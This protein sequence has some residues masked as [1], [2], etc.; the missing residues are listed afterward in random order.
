MRFFEWVVGLTVGIANVSLTSADYVPINASAVLDVPHTVT[1]GED[2][3]VHLNF[4][5]SAKAG[6][7]HQYMEIYAWAWTQKEVKDDWSSTQPVLYCLLD[8][9]VATNL[10][11]ISLNVPADALPD[12]RMAVSYAL[13]HSDKVGFST[14]GDQSTDFNLTGGKATLSDWEVKNG[15]GAVSHWTT[16]LPCTSVDC[17]RAC[18][19]EHLDLNEYYYNQGSRKT[20]FE[21]CV[22]GC[23]GL[24]AMGD[25]SSRTCT[26][27]NATKTSSEENESATASSSSDAASSSVDSSG[28]RAAGSDLVSIVWVAMAIALCTLL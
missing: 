25:Y 6:Y 16:R 18:I 15:W 8:P 5:N 9:C 22:E 19:E 3:L 12:A 28:P 2:T 1:A 17:A 21:A 13:F 20:A 14:W 27:E 11:T 23:P 26:V 24:L 4:S 7:E 10:T